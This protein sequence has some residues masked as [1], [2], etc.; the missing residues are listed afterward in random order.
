MINQKTLIAAFTQT[1]KPNLFL[2]NLLIGSSKAEKTEKFEIQTKVAQRKRVP[3]V[4]RREYGKLVREESF[5]QGLYQPS[6]IKAYKVIEEDSLLSQK[7][8]ETVYGT[9]AS[10]SEAQKQDFQGQ[11]LDLKEIGFRTKNWML[12]QL[13]T[14]GVL[15]TRDGA[16]GIE[17][18]EYNSEVLTG[19][20]K[21]SNPDADIIAQLR[22]KKI[23]IH[24]ETGVVVDHLIITP[25][26]TQD[27]LANNKIKEAFKNINSSGLMLYKPEELPEGTEYL[28]Y[29]AELNLKIYAY[30]DWTSVE[31]KD[32][33]AL[34]PEGTALLLRKGSFR[35][36]YGALA[37]RTKANSAKTL[38]ITEEFVKVEYGTKD[39]EDDELKYYSAPLIVPNDARGW[40]FIKVK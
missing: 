14:T 9:K 29:I 39:N 10:Y 16:E 33:E 1:K 40:S 12:C 20:E 28:G 7:F 36:H 8:G 37:L 24:K 21:W 19:D 32:E 6:H 13:L 17:Y 34:L 3:L 5:S 22:M 23:E 25:D 30:I 27:L 31:G 4:G 18:G 26:V 11:L 35:T 15:P 38:V 2:Y